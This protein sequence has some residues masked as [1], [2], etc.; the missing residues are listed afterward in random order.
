MKTVKSIAAVIAG[1]V[2]IV[3]LSV[4]T[5]S[6]LETAGIFTPPDEGLFVPWMLTLALVYRSVY[7]IAGGYATASLAPDRP[8]L[9]VVILGTIGTVAS[10]AGAIVGWDLSAHWYPVALII[11]SLPFTILGGRLKLNREERTFITKK[12]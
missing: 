4:E 12:V 1:V 8:M 10:I 6:I 9:H 7:A 11:T 3:V 5:D 2:T